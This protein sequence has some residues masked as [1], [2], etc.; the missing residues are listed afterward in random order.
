[1]RVKEASLR[2]DGIVSTVP[3]GLRLKRTR[4]TLRMSLTWMRTDFVYV[5]RNH[6]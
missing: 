5:T 1:M 3:T 4:L 2:V 6:S